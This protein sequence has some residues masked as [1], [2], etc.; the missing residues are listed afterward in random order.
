M[1]AAEDWTSS[2]A[3]GVVVLITIGEATV[4]LNVDETFAA[5]PP[6]RDQELTVRGGC[7][8]ELLLP[9]QHEV[10]GHRNSA[11]FQEIA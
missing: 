9:H 5:G 3:A 4:R 11:V 10:A 7:I 1:P 8:V 2:G 6:G